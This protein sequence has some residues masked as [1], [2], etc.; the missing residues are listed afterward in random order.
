LVQL[1]FLTY[2]F[3]NTPGNPQPV[4][5]SIKTVASFAK[6]VV[7]S[8]LFQFP[9]TFVLGGLVGWY[10]R[11]RGLRRPPQLQWFSSFEIGNLAP[12]EL[13]QAAREDSDAYAEVERQYHEVEA[14]IYAFGQAQGLHRLT[15][16][17]AVPEA[18]ELVALREKL[19]EIVGRL[20]ERRRRRNASFSR[21]IDFIYENLRNGTLI[22]KGCIA[23]V[24]PQSEEIAIPAW[25]WRFLRF[26][27]DLTEAAGEDLSYKAVGVAKAR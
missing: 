9:A 23:P 8:P 10:A 7:V 14:Q 17:M 5:T 6:S 22:S 11:S 19:R 2:T 18:D 26:N 21:A 3:E 13:V 27:T 1:I 20:E 4:S 16:S 24:T 25:Q 12:D 15:T